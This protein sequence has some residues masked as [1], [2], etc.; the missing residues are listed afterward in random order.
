VSLKMIHPDQ[1]LAGRK[2]HSLGELD[3]HKQRAHQPR[4]DRDGDSIQLRG[5]NT[6]LFQRGI[7]DRRDVSE[8]VAGGQF[9]HHAAV[10][11]MH[12]DL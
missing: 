10:R 9:R 12:L 3:A 8:M 11:L 2:R 1:W 4:S 7:D 5:L 6:R